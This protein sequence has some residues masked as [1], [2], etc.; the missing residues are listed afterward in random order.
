[1]SMI[2]PKKAT[3]GLKKIRGK[4]K[5]TGKEY[6]GYQFT[7]GSYKS[8]LIFPQD[9][10]VRNYL[11]EFIGEDARSNFKSGSSD[12]EPLDDLDD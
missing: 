6:E 2:S 4:S 11:D 1:M 9:D 12:D 8:P 3:L 10:I 7:C 5:N